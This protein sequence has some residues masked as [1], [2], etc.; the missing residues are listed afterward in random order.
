[1]FKHDAGERLEKSRADEEEN[2]RGGEKTVTR[3]E[4]GQMYGMSEN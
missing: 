1:M 3:K 4:K 2:T